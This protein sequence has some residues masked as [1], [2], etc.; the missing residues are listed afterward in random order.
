MAKFRVDDIHT[1]AIVGHEQAGKTSL[2]DALLYKAKATDRRGNVDDGTSFSD[3]DQEEKSHKYSIDSAVLH[4]DYEGRRIYLID[5]PGKPDFVGQAL[6]ALAAVDCVAVVVSATAGVQ[7]NTRRMIAEAGKRGL[8]RLL[9]IN[10]MDGDNVHFPELLANIRESLG[11]SCVLFDAPNGVG[12][13]FSG[14]LSVLNPPASPPAGMP[15]DLAAERSRLVDAIV[16]SDEA[17]MEKYLSEGDVSNDELNAALP[18]AMAAGAI[19]P[20]FCTAAKAG[21]DTGV[22]ELLDAITKYAPSPKHA[23]PRKGKKGT[24]DKATEV[25]IVADESGELVAQVF[26]TISDKFVGNLSYF[27]IFAGKMTADQQLYIQR[28]GKGTRI[29]GLLLPQGKTTQPIQ[30]AVPGDIVAVAKVEDLHIGDTISNHAGAPVLPKPAFPTPMF[31]LAIEPKARGDEQKISGSLHKISEEDPMFRVSRDAQTKEM[32]ITGMSQLHLD[33]VQRRLKQRYDLEVITH[34]PKIPYRETVTGEAGAEHRHKKQ[35]G[36]RGQ[37]GE[38]HLRVYPLK[39]FDIHSEQDLTDRFANKEKFEKLRAAHYDADHNFAFI[40]HI[41]GGSI[42]NQFIPA[43]EKG[44]KELLE[45]GALA[46]YRIQDVAVEVHFGKDHPVDSSEA[47]FKTAGRMAFKKAFRE[48]HPVLLEP[49]VNLEVTVPSKYTGAILS[50]LNTKRARIENQDSLPGDL[51]VIQAK[52]P[53]AEVTRYAA[54]LG[55]ITQG[56]GSYSME[57]SHYDIVPGNVQQQIV[58]KA[59]LAH[60]EEE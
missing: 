24:G 55:S 5:T 11:K 8:A 23:A 49:I 21:K 41:V 19:V 9:V 10:K 56:S 48:A 25:T 29:S 33:T 6:G 17:L 18:R 26:K 1:V 12:P 20:I 32:V 37:F 57:F 43:V 53:L 27:R 16:E 42:P 14:A 3:F 22:Q 34:E 44:C 50:D 52:A 46:G 39:D 15:V 59:K 7:V 30:E 4:A 36:G 40:D 45:Q 38:V 2:A 58:A 28:T 51:A 60:D 13:A 47:A 35:S 54:Q 31:G